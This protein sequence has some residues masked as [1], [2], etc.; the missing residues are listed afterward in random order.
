VRDQR[1][2]EDDKESEVTLSPATLLGIFLGLVLVC[3]VFFGFG[4]SVGRRAPSSGSIPSADSNAQE[5]DTPVS[6]SAKPSAARTLGRDAA[7]SNDDPSSA[8]SGTLLEPAASSPAP[9]P[10]ADAPVTAPSAAARPAAATGLKDLAQPPRA[11]AATGQTVVQVAAVTRQ[12]DADV[13]VSALRQRGYHAM[14]LSEPQDK[15]VHV[16][17]GPFS[18]REE[19][20]AMRQKLLADGYN[21]IIK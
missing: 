20:N 11:A 13:L 12:E 6:P 16:Q 21:A 19:A 2:R 10:V 9:L 5:T 7:A 4:Y 8:A 17:V 15:L 3:G 1:Q 18:S 14:E